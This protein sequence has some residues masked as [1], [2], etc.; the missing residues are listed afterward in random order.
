VWFAD[1]S[2][3]EVRP[4]PIAGHNSHAEDPAVVEVSHE[5]LI[6]REG[7]LWITRMTPDWFDQVPLEIGKSKLVLMTPTEKFDE[8]MASPRI[9]L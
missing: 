6:D 2:K 8:R 4:V 7:A 5:M 9:R 3:G 1:D